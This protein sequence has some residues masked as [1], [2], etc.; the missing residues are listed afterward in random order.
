VRWKKRNGRE[1]FAA[2]LSTL[3][4]R[5]VFDLLGE[6]PTQLTDRRA[7]ALAYAYLYDKRGGAIEIEIK[8][9]KQGFGLTKRNKKRYYAQQ[10]I[11]LLSALAHNVVVWSRG[12]LSE[13]TKVRRYG[14]LRMVRDVFHV[15]G[16]VEVGAKGAIKRIVLSEAA[17]WARR[18][19][20]PLRAL[21]KREHVR[22]SLG[23]T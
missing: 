10:M 17:V 16:F 8:E 7:V 18:C 3:E 1:C 5:Q 22:V 15:C 9:D 12:W 13:A 21:L 20:N 11:V 4:P 23:E 19:A 2:R 14:V 6:S